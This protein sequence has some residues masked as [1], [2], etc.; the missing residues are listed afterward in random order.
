MPSKPEAPITALSG[1]NVI[2][3]WTDPSNGGSPIT[4]YVISLQKAD[5]TFYIDSSNCAGTNPAVIAA[6][7]CSIPANSFVS[8]VYNLIWGNNVYAKVQAINAYGTSV[9]SALSAG[10]IIITYPDVPISLT[11]NTALRSFT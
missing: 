4:G 2:V 6:K 10:T 1:A 7:S 11:E 3:T 5:L 9:A 8:P